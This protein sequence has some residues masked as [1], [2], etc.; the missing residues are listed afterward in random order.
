MRVQ[1]SA[2]GVQPAVYGKNFFGL[3]VRVW[4]VFLL[5]LAMGKGWYK[6]S[7]ATI[8]KPAPSY[9]ALT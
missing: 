2:H 4:G 9:L 8:Q 6:K 7:F 5:F 1:F 3:W